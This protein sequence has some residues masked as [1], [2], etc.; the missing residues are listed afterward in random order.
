MVPTM[1]HLLYIFKPKL[2]FHRVRTDSRKPSNFIFHLREYSK[3]LEKGIFLTQL[4]KNANFYFKTL[5]NH[6]FGVFT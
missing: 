2:V 3:I 1:Q 6:W 4:S 5:E